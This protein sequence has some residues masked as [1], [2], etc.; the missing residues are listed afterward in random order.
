[1][2]TEIKKINEKIRQGSAEFVADV[3]REYH[4]RIKSE[5]EKNKET[6]H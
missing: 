5:A 3:E 1:M 4:Q 2:I 6:R